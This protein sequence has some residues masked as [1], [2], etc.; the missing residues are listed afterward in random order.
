MEALVNLVDVALHIKQL[1][2]S[3]LVSYYPS[4]QPS[5]QVVNDFFSKQD[6]HWRCAWKEA[7][8]TLVKNAKFK[9]ERIGNREF[10]IRL[11]DPF[12]LLT[13]QQQIKLKDHQPASEEFLRAEMAHQLIH[14]HIA[15]LEYDIVT[16]SQLK[17][18]LASTIWSHELVLSSLNETPDS[19][20]VAFNVPF[21]TLKNVPINE[22][23]AVRYE[24]GDAFLAFRGAITRAAE[25]MYKNNNRSDYKIL[26]VQIQRDVIEPELARLQQRLKSAQRAM[27]K[28]SLVSVGMSAMGTLCALKLGILTSAAVGAVSVASGIAGLVGS[29]S[30]Y[31][32][33]KQGIEMSDMYFVWK[34][35]QHAEQ[36]RSGQESPFSKNSPQISS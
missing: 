24:N 33:E 22:L 18:P 28:K 1:G 14:T 19:S 23:L 9:L 26:G 29:T 27:A 30:K 15:T 5:S 17:G 31:I 20:Q 36:S 8:A 4:I 34:A 2:A 6:R 13:V 32:D 35:L 12:L 11:S 7:E 21:P 25:D 16:A 3:H 10:L